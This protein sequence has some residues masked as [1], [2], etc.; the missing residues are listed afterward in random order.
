[1]KRLF[2]VMVLMMAVLALNAQRTPV[3]V[4]DL[5]KAIT[6]NIAKD[7]SGFTIKD[8][9]QVINNGVTTF[10]VVIAKG[11]TSETLSYDKDGKFLN[12][13]TMKTGMTE[14]PVMKGKSSSEKT[15]HKPVPKKR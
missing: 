15:T 4:S 11:A 1:M 9:T 7:Y 10:E 5:N 13:V 12:K 6:D 8:A 2:V 14:K 3:K